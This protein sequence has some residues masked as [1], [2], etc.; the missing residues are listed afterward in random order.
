MDFLWVINQ[1]T[2]RD[3]PSW[4]RNRGTK[5]SVAS[6]LSGHHRDLKKKPKGAAGAGDGPLTQGPLRGV[7]LYVYIYIYAYIMYVC[8]IHMSRCQ[9]PF[10]FSWFAE[11]GCRFWGGPIA[12]HGFAKRG[13]EEGRKRKGKGKGKGKEK[14]KERKGKER[15]RKGKGKEEERKRTGKRKGK[16]LGRGKEK[17]SKRKGKGHEGK[18]KRNGK[19]KEKEGKRKGREK[20]RSKGRGREKEE[21][22]KDEKGKDLFVVWSEAYFLNKWVSLRYR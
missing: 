17:E 6:P 22:K 4:P 16:G 12:I 8:D 1:L 2:Q 18:R 11:I 15:K 3:A 21:R 7:H 14:E 5:K 9:K 19:E 20:E 10:V 13:K